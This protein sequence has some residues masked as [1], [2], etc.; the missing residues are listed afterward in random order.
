MTAQELID[1]L[2][3]VENKQAWVWFVSEDDDE[4]EYAVNDMIVTEEYVTLMGVE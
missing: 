3:K 1:M 2:Q 4:H